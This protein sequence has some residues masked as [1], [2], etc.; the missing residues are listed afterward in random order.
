MCHFCPLIIALFAFLV[1]WCVSFTYLLSND[2]V[3]KLQISAF[4]FATFE[5]ADCTI[6]AMLVGRS[7]GWLVGVT[8]NFPFPIC[9]TQ[10][11]TDHDQV[12]PFT[13]QYHPEGGT[14]Y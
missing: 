10:L 12:P 14:L 6:L 7:V 3:I 1:W 11:H 2:R 4:Y 13:I 5:K 9:V 8:I